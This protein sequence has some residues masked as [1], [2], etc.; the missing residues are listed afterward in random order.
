MAVC[1]PAPLLPPV[2]PVTVK[3][4]LHRND[5]SSHAG[6]MVGVIPGNLTATD[7]E[8]SF[9]MSVNRVS[10]SY[11]AVA[12]VAARGAGC[13]RILVGRTGTARAVP[14]GDCIYVDTPRARTG[15]LD[16]AR[17]RANAGTGSE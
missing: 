12:F 9:T 6:I 14:E 7:S 13:W 17:P 5:Q 16:Y 15:R 8:G 2:P 11:T 10:G 4:T 1:P 3:G